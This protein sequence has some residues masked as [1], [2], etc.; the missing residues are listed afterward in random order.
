VLVNSECTGRDVRG[1]LGV[2]A[3]RVLV[4]PLGAPARNDGP[5]RPGELDELRAMGV[6]PP[7]VLYVGLQSPHKNLLRLIEAF[8]GD[9]ELPGRCQLV[10][11][12]KLDPRR[13]EVARAVETA[14]PA[15]RV[16]RTG[17]V[18]PEILDALYR[19][20]S[21][22]VLPSLYEGFGL[23]V[24]EAM[25]RGT[26][27]AAS[28]AASI[29]EAAGDAAVYFDP[30]SIPEMRA[31]IRRL[32]DEPGLAGELRAKGF[33][34]VRRRSWERCAELTVEGYRAAAG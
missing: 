22:F 24:L 25:A 33:E 29:P 27:V 14:R 2:P 12:G 34:Q 15:G 7:F 1:H 4:T 9:P 16:L 26:P 32:L 31:A 21:A 23:P 18:S 20:A 11:A 10:L 8:T 3:E 30:R 19:Q 6:Q 13:L 28:S 17:F 5:V